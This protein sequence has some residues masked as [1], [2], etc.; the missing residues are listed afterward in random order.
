MDRFEDAKLRVK[1]AT[2][3]V[4]L[5]EG[6]MPLKSRGRLQLALCPFHAEKS[7]S[8][9]VY[10]DSQ[11]YH[12]Y[13]CGKS[14][15]VFTF[16]MDREGLSFREAMENLADRAN[17]PLEGVFRAG[18]GGPKRGPDARRVLAEVADFFHRCLLQEGPTGADSG[19]AAARQYLEERSLSEGIETWQLGYHPKAQPGR[20]GPLRKFAESR[21]LPMRLLEEAGLLRG[22]R[23]PFGGRLLFPIQDERSRMVAFGGRVLP[24]VEP[25]RAGD[26]DPPKYINSPESPFFNKRRVMFGLPRAKQVGVRRILVVEGYTDAIA[27][28]I[29]GFPGAVATLGTAFTAE[30]ARK[31][32]RYATE[33]V[34]L[35]FDGDQAGAKAAERAMRELVNSRLD[36]QIALLASGQDPATMLLGEPDEDRDLVLERRARFGDLLDGAEQALPTWLQLLRR[37]L[38][39]RQPAQLEVAARECAGLL[40]L[41]ESDLRR[42]A[43]LEEMARYLAVP[44]QDLARMIRTASRRKPRANPTQQRGQPTDLDQANHQADMAT[45]EGGAVSQ[46]AEADP[47]TAPRPA[48]PLELADRDLLACVLGRPELVAEVTEES[49]AQQGVGELIAMVR[50]AVQAGL[51][52]RAQVV[53]RLFTSCTEHAELRSVLASASHRAE[54][55]ADFDA[56]FAV[57]QRG[58][59]RV[60]SRTSVRDLRQQL[61]AARDSGDLARADELMQQI[62]EE[63]RRDQP[64][65][66]TS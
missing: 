28:D 25:V 26:F 12:C 55:I 31:I 41:V 13:G 33:G 9:T 56:F 53:G 23:E 54:S 50:Q 38:D 59:N 4:A 65:E 8:F 51:S 18:A 61:Q 22:Q 60:R 15:D 36:V 46:S 21:G 27:C 11:H 45:G 30:H 43:V 14:G 20:P 24:G 52:E 66:A 7:P 57:L 1:E 32:E 5:I 6:Y 10:P 49:F 35:L 29:A 17:I 62:V 42:R 40:E 37:R 34:V 44:P 3:L 47:P 58:R 63:R 19:A 2:D 48:T 39:F 16:L 64:R